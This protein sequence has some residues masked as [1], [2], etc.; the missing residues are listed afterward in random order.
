MSAAYPSQRPPNVYNQ[1]QPRS[2]SPGQPQYRTHAANPVNSAKSEPLLTVTQYHEYRPR[3]SPSVDTAPNP[4]SNAV[5]GS[6]SYSGG[7][8]APPV[9]QTTARPSVAEQYSQA[10]ATVDPTAVYDMWPEIQRNQEKERQRKAAED[11][12]RAE[13]ER[14]AE[15]VR[16]QEE[17]R[18]KEVVRKAEELRRQEMEQ[19][20]FRR[21]EEAHKKEQE[22]RK[23][24]EE[25]LKE[26]VRKREEEQRVSR[27]IALSQQRERAQQQQS[28]AAQPGANEAHNAPGDAPD[29]LESEIRAMMAKMR[30]LNGKDPALLARIFEEERQAKANGQSMPIPAPASAQPTQTH[31]PRATNPRKKATPKGP[32]NGVT[33]ARP[34]SHVP[35]MSQPPAQQLPTQAVAPPPKAVAPPTV[36]QPPTHQLPNSEIAH[37]PARPASTAIWP[38]G[39]KSVQLA[40]VAAEYLNNINPDKRVTPETILSMLETNPS[41]ITLCEILESWNL[42]LDRAVLAKS[43]LTAVPDLNSGSRSDGHPQPHMSGQVVHGAQRIQI[44]PAIITTTKRGPKNN[45]ANTAA[46]NP[47]KAP[48]QHPSNDDP[49]PPFPDDNIPSYSPA[50]VAEMGTQMNPNPVAQTNPSP[51]AQMNPRPVAQMHSRRVSNM[52]P[53]PVAHVVGPPP[54]AQTVT[55]TGQHPLAEMVP[56]APEVINAETRRPANKEEAARKRNFSDLID[57]TAG[58]ED[59]MERAKKRKLGPLYSYDSVTF[60]DD[61]MDIDQGTSPISNFPTANVPSH[62]P[63]VAVPSTDLRNRVLVQHL[64]RRKALKRN[65]YNFKTIARDVLLACGRH[66]EE[67]QLNGHLDPLRKNLPTQIT[68]EADLT[69]LKWD[70]IDPGQPPKG[71]YRHGDQAVAEDA[72]DEEDSDD[73]A[74][75]DDRPG[76]APAKSRASSSQAIGGTAVAQALP[77]TN[78]FVKRRGRGRP[79]RHSSPDNAAPQTPHEKKPKFRQPNMSAST[80]HG[81]P[82]PKKIGRP[83][84]W[85]KSIHGKAAAQGQANANGRTAP[86]SANRHAPSQPSSLRQVSTGNEPISIR[87]SS[88]S[89]SMQY[90]S[91]ACQW[92][93]CKADLHNLET[94][95]K[96]VHKVHRKKVPELECCW[97]ECG[98]GNS[99]VFDDEA[100]WREHLEVKHFGPLAWE[101]GDG[102]ASGLSGMWKLGRIV[103]AQT[104]SGADAHDSEAYLSDAHGRRVTPRISVDQGPVSSNRGGPRKVKPKQQ[105]ALDA[106][107]RAVAHTKHVGGPGIDR[108]GATLVNEKRRRGFIDNYEAEDI[109]DISD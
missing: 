49:Y 100:G 14:K 103:T 11:A 108:G 50:P 85:R 106:L 68:T 64:D 8:G 48:I 98:R 10:T 57:L 35:A 30:E 47:Q 51:V 81:Q 61:D 78:P 7:K 52:G 77:P 83:V 88:R 97:G 76:A 91:F 24:Q 94:L 43:L 99:N 67:R 75:S 31:T 36:N 92:Q 38:A 21:Q 46:S 17:E 63:P 26:E 39:E 28:F 86:L 32:P 93:N 27:Q 15:E 107:N 33:P 90:Q 4:Q 19:I 18:K 34:Q 6:Y 41:Y 55:E 16:R 96:H 87:S 73:E 109:V 56:A 105:T 2:D 5:L 59:D 12:A 66:P 62:P 29:A 95:K 74:S 71:F 54:V 20:K 44:P 22:A 69:T 58:S 42:K 101:L 1:A 45:T 80:P 65:S 72:D 53:Q 89:V 13:E 70:L 25:R 60:G 104:D 82:L 102:P 23:Q 40:R 84:G 3:R 79:P 37:N 9:T